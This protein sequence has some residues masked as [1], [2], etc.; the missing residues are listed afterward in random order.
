MVIHRNTLDATLIMFPMLIHGNAL[1]AVLNMFPIGMDSW[2]GPMEWTHGMAT[3]G[4]AMKKS[5][6]T[7]LTGYKTSIHRVPQS[8]LKNSQTSCGNSLVFKE[9]I[10]MTIILGDGCGFFQF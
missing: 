1:D 2:K 4:S 8:Y 5:R 3:V 10:K 9:K 6:S 7:K